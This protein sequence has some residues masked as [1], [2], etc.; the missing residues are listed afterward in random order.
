MLSVIISLIVC[1]N[2]LLTE[3]KPPHIVFI[4]ADD[5]GWNDV[6]WHNPAMKTPNLDNL[7]NQGVILNSSYVQPL[8]TPSRT[9][10]MSGYYPYRTGL[11]HNVILPW[12][13]AYLRRNYTLL[14]EKLKNVGYNTHMIGK[15]HLGFCNWNYTPTYRG[16]DS[17]YGYYNG[18]EDYYSHKIMFG[19]DY[20][21]DKKV[22]DDKEGVYS[23]FSY[24]ERAKKIIESHNTSDPMFLYLAFQ[25]VHAPLQ[26]PKRFEDMYSNIN[27]KNRRIY[28]GMVS[29][30]DEAVGNITKSL[31]QNGFM[32]NIL[33]VFTADNGGI[34][35]FG[36]NN[37]PLRGAKS[38]L[39]EGGTKGASFVYS[40]TL[41]DKTG[42][43]NTE[44]MHATDWFATFLDVAGGQPEK[45]VDGISQWDMLRTGSPSKRNEF[46]Y[47]IDEINKNAAIRYGDLKLIEGSAGRFN[48]WYP[49]P[50]S[51][52]ENF[53]T[54]DHIYDLNEKT[55]L[56][57][58]HFEIENIAESDEPQYR[59]FNITADPTEHFDIAD[60]FPDLVTKLKDKLVEYKKLLVPAFDPSFS[61]KSLP[62]FY[63]GVW[64]PGWC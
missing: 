44:M 36:G 25:D 38:T 6:G 56:G 10:F 62:I 8:C 31:V 45:G 37:L 21:D 18:Q 46:I 28:S 26:V 30:L 52:L 14:P 9:A 33:I 22:V 7:A 17:F 12:S 47:N 57:V 2:I 19:L 29:A 3:S 51:N 32:D 4:V 54:A 41:L 63:D 59:L 35:T 5:L 1:Y 60:Q 42:Y 50:T 43:I 49:V 58:E 39:W 34:P 15:W 48:D 20:R 27:D 40:P 11:Q 16:F 64:T 61:P 55:D 23:A 24:T 53:K 13:A